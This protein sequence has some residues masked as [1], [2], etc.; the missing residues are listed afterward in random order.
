MA[1][2]RYEKFLELT[3]EENQADTMMRICAHVASGGT[4]IEWCDVMETEYGYISGWLRE[5]KERSRRWVDCQND[6]KEW[7]KDRLLLELKRIMSSDIRKVFDEKGNI[8]PVHEW[9]DE[10]ASFV[11]SIEVVEEF[12]G[13]G[14]D[15][16]QTGWNKKLKLWNKEK[17]IEML[18]KYIGML[19]ETVQHS[20]K[21][22][23]EDLVNASREDDE[24]GQ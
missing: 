22:T 23:L 2:D 21:I 19:T 13:K 12:E 24:D 15:R 20:G 18:G 8:K 10:V 16:E 11:A 17:G 3:S 5:D 4:L 1:K 14:R 6:R 9:P 7:I